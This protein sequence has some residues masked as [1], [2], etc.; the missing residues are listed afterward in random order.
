MSCNFIL[1]NWISR[2]T[3]LRTIRYN[4]ILFF[5]SK[6]PAW[7]VFKSD[8]MYFQKN[9]IYST[10]YT[11]SIAIG[12]NL[13]S[14]KI[15][16]RQSDLRFI[17]TATAKWHQYDL[18]QRPFYQAGVVESSVWAVLSCKSGHRNIMNSSWVQVSILR[19][20]ESLHL[21]LRGD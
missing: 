6:T 21:T 5:M 2:H 15:I 3:L 10:V 20:C 19:N 13:V 7:K 9:W 11:S 14:Q 12:K 16:G 18:V 8:W 1:K 4:I 17:S